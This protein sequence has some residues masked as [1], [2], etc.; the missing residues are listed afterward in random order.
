MCA[1]TALK[2]RAGS[3]QSARGWYRRSPREG[4]TWSSSQVREG[5]SPASG[6]LVPCMSYCSALGDALEWLHSSCERAAW[7][8]GR[9]VGL[10]PHSKSTVRKLNSAMMH[11]VYVT[12]TSQNFMG[13]R[14]HFIWRCVDIMCIPWYA[15]YFWVSHVQRTSSEGK[16]SV[17]NSWLYQ[18]TTA[19]SQEGNSRLTW[20]MWAIE[21]SI[22]FLYVPLALMWLLT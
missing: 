1:F 7:M 5:L 19:R 18:R 9:C 17:G 21:F 14:L 2:C 20:K 8:L 12:F 10:S 16:G 11:T 22:S 15:S 6:T 4:T 13:A 3:Y